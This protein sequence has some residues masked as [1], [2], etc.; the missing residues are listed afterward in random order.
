MGYLPGLTRRLFG[1]L[2]ASSLLASTCALHA[3]ETLNLGYAQG[4]GL[5]PFW[6]AID[7]NYFKQ[8]EL[9]VF[10]RSPFGECLAGRCESDA[11]S[12]PNRTGK[13]RRLPWQ[14]RFP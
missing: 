7:G 13:G 3:A 9:E 14:T 1:L 2:V 11:F 10:R 6:V 5:W 8:N 12:T 4:S